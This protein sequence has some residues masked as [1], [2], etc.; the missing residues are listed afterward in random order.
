MRTIM[1]LLIIAGLISYFRG[2]FKTEHPATYQQGMA[3]I[4]TIPHVLGQMLTNELALLPKKNPSFDGPTTKVGQPS[5]A[6]T[7][8]SAPGPLSILSDLLKEITG[9]NASPTHQSDPL[10]GLSEFVTG[11]PVQAGN[12]QVTGLTQSEVGQLIGHLKTLDLVQVAPKL[13]DLSTQI[14]QVWQAHHSGSA[15]LSAKEQKKIESLYQQTMLV[16]KVNPSF[17]IEQG[18]SQTQ[19]PISFAK[20]LHTRDLGKDKVTIQINDSSN[21][22][23]ASFAVS[24]H[25]TP[26]STS[27]LSGKTESHPF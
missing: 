9:A 2:P 24:V 19:T 6:E 16:L 1:R 20:L 4:K 10:S 13:Q 18:K 17:S 11:S 27:V 22:H 15:P 26:S 14:K 23:L 3:T 8:P 21:H 7:N 5:T 25:Q 12:V